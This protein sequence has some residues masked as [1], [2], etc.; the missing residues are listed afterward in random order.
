MKRNVYVITAAGGNATAIKVLADKKNRLYYS[1][2]GSELIKNYEAQKV[3]QS[4]FLILSQNRFEM[5][6]GEFCG[7]AA[8]A[9]ALL[10]S[11]INRKENVNFTM[12]GF[13]GLVKSKVKKLSESDYEVNCFFSGMRPILTKKNLNQPVTVVDLGGIVHVIIEAE[14]PKD[15]FKE[16]HLEISRALNLRDR[17]A[18]GVIWISKNKVGVKIDPLVWV[19]EID[20]FFY[21]SACGSGSI[22]TACVMGSK[23]IIQPSGGVI[24]VK[25]SNKGINLKSRMEVKNETN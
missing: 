9:A 4:G 22:A 11:K 25:V 18:V 20:S 23:K 15:N 2:F 12:S 13:N 10:L 1:A 24:E 3:E 14:F 6:G 21:E 5:S 19:R 7:N 17:E 8:R 16:K